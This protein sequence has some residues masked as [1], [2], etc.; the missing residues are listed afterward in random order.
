MSQQE[1]SLTNLP[2]RLGNWGRA[3]LEAIRGTHQDFTSGSLVLFRGSGRLT[4]R[5]KAMH[6]N[7]KLLH[8]MLKIS[9][10]GIVQYL[11]G[12]ASWIAIIRLVAAFGSEAVA[13]YTIGVRVAIFAILP[14]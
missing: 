3:V 6:M 8:R 13:G 12:S 11:V 4:I 14:A 10:P 9:G 7:G 2:E 5:R 1:P